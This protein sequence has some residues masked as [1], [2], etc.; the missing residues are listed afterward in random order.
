MQESDGGGE[1]MIE[2]AAGAPTGAERGSWGPASDGV[3][4]S[5]G[6]SPSGINDHQAVR[7][8][9]DGRSENTG[10]RVRAAVAAFQAVAL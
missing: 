1:S 8:R 6:R 10:S 5:E 9:A 7:L 4:E 2:R 3:G